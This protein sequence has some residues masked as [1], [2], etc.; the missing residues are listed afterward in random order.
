[1]VVGKAIGLEIKS[2]A[3]HTHIGILL[4]GPGDAFRV[5]VQGQLYVCSFDRVDL[6][7]FHDRMPSATIRTGRD[8]P[9]IKLLIDALDQF[10][11]QMFEMLDRAKALGVFQSYEAAVTPTDVEH[12]ADLDRAFR[13]DFG[14]SPIGDEP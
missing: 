9:Y 13:E 6:F 5:Q 7:A 10:N 14:L 8:E 11:A 2:T 4:D 1:V 12:A 3:P